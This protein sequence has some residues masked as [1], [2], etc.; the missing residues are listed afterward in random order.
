MG[1]EREGGRVERIKVLT[2]AVDMVLGDDST[3]EAGTNKYTRVG[4]GEYS[5]WRKAAILMGCRRR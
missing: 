3:N 1:V 4:E 2:E 5:N